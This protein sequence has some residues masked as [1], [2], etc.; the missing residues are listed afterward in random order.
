MF[1]FAGKPKLKAS[2]ETVG[3]IKVGVGFKDHFLSPRAEPKRYDSQL[4]ALLYA[5]RTT[6]AGAN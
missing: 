3:C 1:S 5:A 4:F 6:R 2:K